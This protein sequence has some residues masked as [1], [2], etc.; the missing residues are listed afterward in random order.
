MSDITKK[1]FEDFLSQLFKP[2]AEG[3]ETLEHFFNPDMTKYVPEEG[4]IKD[5]IKKGYLYQIGGDKM[6]AVTGYE[7]AVRYVDSCRA[8]GLPDEIIADLISVTESEGIVTGM[9]WHKLSE[10]TWKKNQK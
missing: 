3:D 6:I 7:G 1:E 8:S 2:N 10:I 9:T 5:K 4:G